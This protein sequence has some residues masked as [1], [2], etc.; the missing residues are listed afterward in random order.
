MDRR[1][2]LKATAIVGASAVL[3]TSAL[4]NE[5]DSA[6]VFDKDS[7]NTIASLFALS[8]YPE[9]NL[10]V[11]R[12][13]KYANL[14]GDA[15][16]Y[17][18][19]YKKNGSPSGYVILDANAPGT[20][21]EFSIGEHVISPV[22]AS[23]SN[24]IAHMDSDPAPDLPIYRLGLL[25]FGV[26]DSE[27]D[28]LSTNY[29][30]E[31]DASS[32]FKSKSSKD[33]ATWN[34][35]TIPIANLY[36]NYTVTEGGSIPQWMGIDQNR[37]ISLTGRYACTVTAL[38]VCGG[39]YGLCNTWTDGN[40]YVELWDLTN[41]V[42]DT[43]NTNPGAWWGTTYNRD[44]VPGFTTFASRRGKTIEGYTTAGKPSFESFINHTRKN[45]LSLVHAG[46]NNSQGNRVGHTITVEGF[47]R[48]VSKTDSSGLRILQVYDGWYD[49]VRY[50]NYD[51]A[52][53]T[54]F[55]GTFFSG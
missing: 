51:F 8:F 42:T 44:V 13:T 17:I 38:Y 5:D 25:T 23:R 27:R 10:Q 2:F 54:D 50:I 20:I 55:V 52:R 22:Q 14:N 7:A 45:Q 41:T 1:T 16:G 43:S 35:A 39:Y 6:V 34:D 3:P 24:T 29:D 18:V 36:R 31:I 19:E 40:A 9:L 53:F 37:I 15:S 30:E 33:P 28:V 47:L 11:D 12:M 32:I 26:L 4:A 46:L 48:A 49:S 21:A